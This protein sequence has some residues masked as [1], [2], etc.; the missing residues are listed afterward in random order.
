MLEPHAQWQQVQHCP[1]L[2]EAQE[3]AL[4]LA[5]L[6]IDY[7][8]LQEPTSDPPAYALLVQQ[9]QADRALHELAEYTEERGFWPPAQRQGTA[10]RADLRDVL[11]LWLV[12]LA[13]FLCQQHQAL[14]ADWLEAGRAHAGAI[15]SGEWWRTVT[16]LTLH[17][18]GPHLFG[19]LLFGTLFGFLLSHELGR[20]VGWLGVL[21]AGATGN[22]LNAVMRSAEHVSVGASTAVFAAIGMTMV[23]QWRYH[24]NRG[25]LLQ[26][27]TPPIIGMV[28]LGFLGT[29]GARTDVA[30]HIWGLLSG[31]GAGALLNRMRS[32]LPAANAPQGW[33]E[34]LSLM[35][36]GIAWL[37]ALQHGG[38]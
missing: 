2:D 23:L 16:A 37:L 8:L 20:G 32:R 13:G 35:I 34:A 36:L 17:A 3:Y 24:A 14:G 12:L 31:L 5:A 38:R 7:W 18:D 22:T 29:A 15:A 25:L 28:F 26:R 9:T 30:A 19:N 11:G 10:M 6:G 27:W 1:G 21:L 4:V 33:L